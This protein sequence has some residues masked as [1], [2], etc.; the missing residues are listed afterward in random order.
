MIT[1]P[2]ELPDYV[3]ADIPVQ[4][5]TALAEDLGTGDITALLIPLEHRSTGQIICRD[6]AVICGIPWVNEVFRQLEGD[7]E[8]DWHVAEGDTVTAGTVLCRLQGNSRKILTGERTALNF[9][10]TLSSTATRS[11]EYASAA[12]KNIG[13]LDTRKTLPGLRSAQKYAVLCGGCGNHRLGLFDQFLI[14]ENHIA[15]C[16]S[17]TQAVNEA[18][19]LA[20]GKLVVLEVET[21]DEVREAIEARPD[22]IM[23]D[24]FSGP[25]LNA[26]LELIP[27]EL[28]IE[29]SGNQDLA[30]LRAMKLSRPVYISVGALT[31]HI[32]A[33]D[34]SLRLD[35]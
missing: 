32:S 26:A 15:A 33:V 10:Q 9:L 7:L 29:I 12:G 31:K 3:K 2:A 13:I 8:I 30:S 19:A 28:D 1:L 34:L 24:D 20:P 16:G 4:V 21:L 17:I 18:R 11:R 14:K 5:G 22:R 6:E 25:D 23:L 35:S 27:G